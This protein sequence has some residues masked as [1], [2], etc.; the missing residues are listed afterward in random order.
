[1]VIHLRV[2]SFFWTELNLV[3]YECQHISLVQMWDDKGS[4][5][6]A[7]AGSTLARTSGRGTTRCYPD[8][9]SA[10]GRITAWDSGG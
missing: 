1:V 7:A 5:H 3:E 8:G 6:K 2:P 10:A 9:A 4:Q